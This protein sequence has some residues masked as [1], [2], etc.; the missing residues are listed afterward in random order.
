MSNLMIALFIE[1]IIVAILLIIMVLLQS[2]DEDALSGM[3]AGSSNSSILSHSSTVD[4]VTKITIFLGLCLMVNSFA[5]T[6]IT[7]KRYKK[8]ETLIE[9]FINKQ[10]V[11]SDKKEINKVDT[12]V[13]VDK[14]GTN[15]TQ[16]LD[17]KEIKK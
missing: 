1:Q 2:S 7:D 11:N 6:Y 9:D 4:L 5:L 12:K 16:N 15:K 8:N 17:N 13:N 14:V 3:G 10:N